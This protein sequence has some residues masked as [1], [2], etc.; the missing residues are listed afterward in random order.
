MVAGRLSRGARRYRS[1]DAV[2]AAF[3]RAGVVGGISAGAAWKCEM[4]SL[5][6]CGGGLGRGV[7]RKAGVRGYPPLQL[8]PQGGRG[9]SVPC[10]SV[11]RTRALTPASPVPVSRPRRAPSAWLPRYRGASAPCRN[12]WSRRCCSSARIWQTASITFTTSSA[13]STVSLA[14]S[15][16]PACTILPLSSA[17]QFQR[18]LANCGIRS[19]PAGSGFWRSPERYPHTAATGCPAF[20]SSRYWP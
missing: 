7:S 1:R 20:P 16:T 11:S 2:D 15:I 13:V 3:D 5:P 17:E 6:P 9:L 18:H 8:S 19:R 10:S 14:T 12:W 4:Y